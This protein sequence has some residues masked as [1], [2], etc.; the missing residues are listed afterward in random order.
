MALVTCKECGKEISSEAKVCPHC[1]VRRINVAAR[2]LITIPLLIFLYFLSTANNWMAPSEFIFIGV[3]VVLVL[4]A[5]YYGP[6][7]RK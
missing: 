1:G 2:A 6:R 4:L 7:L 5:V 3:A